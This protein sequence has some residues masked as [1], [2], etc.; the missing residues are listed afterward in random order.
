MFC[1]YC[2]EQIND[3]AVFCYRCGKK[4]VL[5]GAGTQAMPQPET[6]ETVQPGTR[7]AGPDPFT[8]QA[9]VSDPIPDPAASAA[10]FDMEAFWRKNA[11]SLLDLNGHSPM[12]NVLNPKG[13]SRGMITADDLVCLVTYNPTKKPDGN[14]G[15]LCGYALCK[16]GF[17]FQ[18]MAKVST[19]VTFGFIG[20]AVS[21]AGKSI[22]YV[23]YG[24]IAG[25]SVDGDNLLLQ[26]TS[27]ETKKLFMSSYFD[28]QAACRLFGELIG[29][30]H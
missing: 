15:G 16:E 18:T 24:D 4:V 21:T 3:D 20:S 19:G 22:P 7:N 26:M 29:Q 14:N 2:G 1:S 8:Y 23:R 11:W 9:P 13:L 25:I 28:G 6:Q 30:F 17:C 5:P 12:H 27:G 10:A